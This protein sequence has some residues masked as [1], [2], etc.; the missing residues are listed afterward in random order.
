M[1]AGIFACPSVAQ[2]S[3]SKSLVASSN[4]VT[5]LPS[6][7]RRAYNAVCIKSS[8]TAVKRSMEMV[9]RTD[10]SVTRHAGGWIVLGAGLLLVC[11]RSALVTDTSSEASQLQDA[12]RAP[13]ARETLR[14]RSQLSKLD[15]RGDSHSIS[16]HARA[17]PRLSIDL[18]RANAAEL[19]CVEGIGPALARR[20]IDFR[21]NVGRFT[22][23]EQLDEIPG[24]GPKLAAQLKVAVTI[25]D[26]PPTLASISASRGTTQTLPASTSANSTLSETNV[27]R[28]PVRQT[29]LIGR[30]SQHPVN[31]PLND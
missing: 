3:A 7:G 29:V 16:E 6:G 18:N 14:S 8:S 24:V 19:S 31:D 12:E 17:F 22:S 23:L 15:A 28:A 5:L 11:L 26:Q 27:E 30:P 2:F 25:S 4:Q 21:H 1:F 13:S 20:I 10:T 9:E